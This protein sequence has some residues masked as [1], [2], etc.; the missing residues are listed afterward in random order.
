MAGRYDGLPDPSHDKG[1]KDQ[2]DYG[3]PPVKTDLVIGATTVNTFERH[4]LPNATS[5]G[6]HA[7]SHLK[8]GL[9]GFFSYAN[10]DD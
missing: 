8:E 3:M 6:T 5:N 4:V 10:D 1:F 7:K 9:E 2:Y